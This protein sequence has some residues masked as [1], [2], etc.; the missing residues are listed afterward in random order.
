VLTR[1]APH[2]Q[3]LK[4][5][6]GEPT[7]HPEFADII[8]AIAETEISF[9]LFTNARWRN[10]QAVIDLLKAT[11]QCGGLLI[12]LHGPDAATHE[13]F[14]N[15][16]GSFKETYEN[17][18]RATAAGLRVHT[19]TVLTRHNCSRVSEIAALAQSLGAQRAVFNR[20]IG[21]AMPDLEP[22]EQQL[23]HAMRGIEA[24]KQSV[25][26]GQRSAFSVKYG[27]CIPQC[28]ASSSSTG[29]WAGVAYCTIDPWGNMR[30]CS[31]SPLIVGNVLETPVEDLWQSEAMN[32][33]RALL[34]AECEGCGELSTCHGGCRAMIEV[35]NLERDPL[36]TG[37]LPMIERPPRQVALFAG[38]RPRA[39]YTIRPEPFGYVL[40]RGQHFVPVT[41]QAKPI[42][43]TLDGQTTLSEIQSRFGQ[44]SL[45]FVGSLYLQG[46]VELAP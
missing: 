11:P 19:S 3:A 32:R 36:A 24:L 41:V 10:P 23:R 35:R 31:H 6:G 27:N 15:T 16:P 7:L 17:I 25:V 42:L 44:E 5:T 9:T 4:L 26:S 38:A 46:M 20:Y 43:D 33:W 2:V 1:I 8:H 12:S 22:E 29:C 13:A 21:P 34:P 30:P 14:T 40:M 18:C 39:L 28:F 45:D 37:P